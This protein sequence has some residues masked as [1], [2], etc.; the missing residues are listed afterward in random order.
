MIESEVRDKLF[1]MMSPNQAQKVKDLEEGH[2]FLVT[3]LKKDKRAILYNPLQ[4]KLIS[5][6][7]GL[8][9]S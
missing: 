2:N 9:R 3:V 4:T 5:V 1:G 8:K 6:P 7:Y